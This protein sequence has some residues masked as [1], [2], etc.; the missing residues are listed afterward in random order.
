[1]LRQLDDNN[2][3]IG[4]QRIE[5]RRLRQ[6]VKLLVQQLGPEL[7]GVDISESRHED[8]EE[9]PMVPNLTL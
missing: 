6:Q 8:G 3:E 4:M 9:E 2:R 1:M 7:A 5:I